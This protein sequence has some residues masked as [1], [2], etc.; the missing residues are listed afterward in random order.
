MGIHGAD[1]PAPIK[2]TQISWEIEYSKSS[3]SRSLN[4]ISAD[5]NK[6][7]GFLCF[8]IF[9]Q[10]IVNSGVILLPMLFGI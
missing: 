6:N 9:K 1:A 3:Q 8:Y 10:M 5:F 2:E 4:T 7:M